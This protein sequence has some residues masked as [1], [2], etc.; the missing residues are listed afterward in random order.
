M[1]KGLVVRQKAALKRL[2]SA[3][4]T[5]KAGGEDKKPR[6]SSRNGG[7]RLIYHEGRSFG[8][9]CERMKKEI[10]ILK[11]KISSKNIKHETSLKKKEITVNQKD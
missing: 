4:E 8:K 7:K 5:F 9:E 11:Q 1:K 2:E 6:T 10:D 3:Y